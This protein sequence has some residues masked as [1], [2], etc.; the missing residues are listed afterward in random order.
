MV[1]GCIISIWF[2]SFKEIN[3]A[4]SF[5]WR[6]QRHHHIATLMKLEKLA[7]FSNFSLS[8]P[9]FHVVILALLRV[10][11][12]HDPRSRPS[13]G[14]GRSAAEKVKRYL[15]MSLSIIVHF[16]C[17]VKLKLAHDWVRYTS[18]YPKLGSLGCVVT[19]NLGICES[20]CPG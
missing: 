16:P 11:S 7:F 3:T 4:F 5:N 19:S 12:S 18:K 6:C 20:P 17:R 2:S 15:R 1:N 14:D 9:W 13:T 10:D 8:H